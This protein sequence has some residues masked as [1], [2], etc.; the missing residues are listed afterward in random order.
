MW[1]F[2][3]SK[4]EDFSEKYL[5]I[6][7]LAIIKPYAIVNKQ[8]V[9]F[10]LFKDSSIFTLIKIRI[11]LFKSANINKNLFKISF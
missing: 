7:I 2:W 1:I 10:L 4:K 6:I 9:I 3:F 8:F 11:N 5:K